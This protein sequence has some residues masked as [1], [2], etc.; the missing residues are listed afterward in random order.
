MHPIM[1]VECDEALVALRADT[2]FREHQKLVFRQVDRLFA[3]LLVVQWL[4]AVTVAIWVSPLAWAGLASQTHPHVLAALLLGGGIV[5][6]P[7][8]MGLARPGL[9]LTRHVIAIG[10]IL[11]GALLIH[12]TGG[13]IETHFHIFGSLAFLAFYRDWRVLVTATLVVASDHFVRGVYWPESVYGVLADG[14]WRWFEHAGWVAFEDAILIPSCLR[15]VAEMRASANRQARLEQAYTGVENT[16]A[17]RTADVRLLQTLTVAIAEAPDELSALTLGLR[18]VCEATGW[19]IGQ[20]WLPGPG[21]NLTSAA[22]FSR[23]GMGEHFLAESKRRTF[24][25]GE[26]LPGLVLSTRQPL[27]VQ[28]VTKDSTFARASVA[29]ADGLGAGVGIP[30]LFGNHALAVIEFF[31]PEAREEDKAHLELVSGVAAQLG[32][33]LLRKRAESQARRMAAD[34]SALVENTTDSIWSVDAALR[35]V[36]FNSFFREGFAWKFAVRPETGMRLPDLFGP[37]DWPIWQGWY[38]RALAGE[39]FVADYWHDS[40]GEHRFF[41]V[42]FNPIT[43]GAE[44]TGVSVFARDVTQRRRAD[45]ELASQAEF[46]ALTANVGLA[47]TRGDTLQKMLQECAEATVRHLGAAFARVWTLDEKGEVLELQASAGLYT[48]IDGQ[49]GRIPVGEFEIGLIAKERRARLTNAAAGDPLISDQEWARRERIVAFAGHPL[50]FEGRLV[51]VMAIFSRQPIAKA[52]LDSLSSI[53][54]AIALG[55][56]RKQTEVE[57]RRAKEAAEAGSRAKSEFLANMSHEIRTP[58]NG[59]LGLTDLVLRTDLDPEQRDYLDGVKFSADLLLRVVNDI[60]DFSKI[61]AGKLD[62]QALDFRLRD[63]LASTMRTLALRA[64]EKSLELAWHVDNAVPEALVGDPIR[65]HQVLVNLVGNA[66]KFTHS[67]EVVVSVRSDMLGDDSVS[68]HFSVRDTGIGIPADKLERIFAP[69]EQVDGS[70]TRN[71]G[72]TGLGLTISARLAAMMDGRVWAESAP[73]QGSTFHFEARFAVAHQALQ[74]ETAAV[75]VGVEDLPVL[76]VDNNTTSRQILGELLAGWHMRPTLVESGAAALAALSAAE[77]DGRPYSLILLDGQMPGMDGF[78]VAERTGQR[79]SRATIMMLTSTEQGAGVARCRALN[80]A[81][82]LVKPISPSDL[83]DAVTGALQLPLQKTP[84]PPPQADVHSKHPQRALRILLAEDNAINQVVAVEMLKGEGHRVEVANNGREVLTALA[85]ESFDLVLM[86][87]QMPE[88]DGFETTAAVRARERAGERRVPIIALTAHA[89]NGDRERCLAA[90]MDAYVT[91]PLCFR[92]LRQAIAE[93]FAGYSNCETQVIAVDRIEAP[94]NAVA[95]TTMAFD[96]SE[97]LS[98]LRGNVQAFDKIVALFL[99]EAPGM[100][101][102][103]RDALTRQDPG[104][105]RRIAHSLKGALSNLGAREASAI[106]FRLESLARE[107]ELDG[108]A[109]ACAE[110]EVQMKWLEAELGRQSQA[111]KVCKVR[112]AG[113]LEEALGGRTHPDG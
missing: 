72:G 101:Q 108:A 90:G 85:R 55:I 31:S 113:E 7:V 109:R 52:A 96:R 88:M 48:H 68:L 99:A 70:N 64:H 30:I 74:C 84:S 17:R 98:R 15:G 60:L 112:A 59:I 46:A 6:L 63:T 24:S 37:T 49:H 33:V 102:S 81:A 11:T 110:L 95:P 34:L 1:H 39:R 61:E 67:G 73:G 13:R 5:S 45:E 57:I 16:V 2:L 105:L 79:Y 14:G 66:I 80:T 58:M 100:A 20:A 104:E 106:A 83:L 23:E 29:A 43:S 18:K 26:R 28:D 35:L 111:S 56:E 77:S 107:G 19:I 3:G 51:G 50:V 82:S 4:A 87:V 91:K 32:S 69:F 44:Y 94:G 89:M 47:L 54:D 10:Q 76:V 25:Q 8:A 93:L 62:M 78:T 41:E 86:D 103:A 36:T 40:G 38:A 9:A 75:P 22:T 97:L 71:Y 65:L 21:G 27:W 92:E 42:A 53:A 12:L